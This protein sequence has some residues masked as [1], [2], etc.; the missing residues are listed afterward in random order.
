MVADFVVGLGKMRKRFL[1]PQIEL[2]V[3]GKKGYV[4]EKGC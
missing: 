2:N 3:C 1:M 4:A